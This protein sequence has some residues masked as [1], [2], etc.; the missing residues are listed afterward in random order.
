MNVKV[1]NIPGEGF[2]QRASVRLLA[3]ALLLAFG[4]ALGPPAR[5]V[6]RSLAGEPLATPKRRTPRKPKLKAANIREAEQRLGELGYWTGRMDGV[7]DQGSRDAL[8]AFQKVEGR[9]RT[10]RLNFNEL[11]A[12]RSAAS[13]RPFEAGPFHVEIDLARQVL[14]IVDDAGKVSKILPVSTGNNKEFE[15]TVG[16]LTAVTPRGRFKIQR[17]I[18]GWRE[19][20]LGLM[21]YPSYIVGGIAIHGSK[22]V[23]AHPASHGC[24]RIPMHAAKQFSEMTPIGTPVIVHDG[25]ARE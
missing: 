19:S 1:R 7:L 13:P 4:A 11:E 16:I 18:D 20:E 25:S 9:T 21:Y 24:I 10:G 6:P 5:G 15:T 2:V 8:L 23:P 14:F 17:K 22:S 3:G 12:L